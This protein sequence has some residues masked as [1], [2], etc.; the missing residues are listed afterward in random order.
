LIIALLD[1]L[2][3]EGRALRRSMVGTALLLAGV[4]V[5]FVLLLIGAVMLLWAAYQ[6]LDAWVGPICASLIG[7]GAAFL[8]AGV[9]AWL[10]V[11]KSRS[12]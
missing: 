4:G 6:A 7:A 3:A 5:V 9:L 12:A 2:E 1:L 11:R 10:I 8:T